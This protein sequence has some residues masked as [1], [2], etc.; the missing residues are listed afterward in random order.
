M[1]TSL[2]RHHH[3]YL[4]E[5]HS[6]SRFMWKTTNQSINQSIDPSSYLSTWKIFL[7]EIQYF[8][9]KQTNEKNIEEK[10]I[11]WSI[12]PFL[13]Q[14]SQIYSLRR[15]HHY[16]TWVEI[17][18]CSSAKSMGIQPSKRLHGNQSVYYK[19][20]ELSSFFSPWKFSIMST[21]RGI[22]LIFD[23]S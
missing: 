20:Y 9:R 2:M 21:H 6:S 18:R 10:F 15:G 13:G 17:D 19:L 7:V 14:G 8:L 11:L 23:R 4:Y 5:R 12:R 1:M 22:D 16:R 3:P